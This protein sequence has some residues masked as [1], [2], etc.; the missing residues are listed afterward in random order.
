[1]HRAWEQVTV[2]YDWC[3]GGLCLIALKFNWFINL[4]ESWWWNKKVTVWPHGW[5][6]SARLHWMWILIHRQFTTA[7]ENW[8]KYQD[9]WRVLYYDHIDKSKHH[10]WQLS[11]D[12]IF[13]WHVPWSCQCIKIETTACWEKNNSCN[14]SGLT[15]YKNCLSLDKFVG[16]LSI[17]H[18]ELFVPNFTP[19]WENLVWVL[20]ILHNE[21]FIPNMRKFSHC[22]VAL[23]RKNQLAPSITKSRCRFLHQYK[24]TSIMYD[25]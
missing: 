5:L 14:C 4:S 15:P 16:V 2:L 13:G 9:A 22:G 21:L 10:H 8:S 20:C 25:E 19:T 3:H 6:W 17:L 18:N 11:M 7:L 12:Q 1:M 23:P 24:E